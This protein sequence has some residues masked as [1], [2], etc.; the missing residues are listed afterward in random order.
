[1]SR[2]VQSEAAEEQR[3]AG[4]DAPAAPAA[5]PD[6]RGW[7]ALAWVVV[8]GSAYALIAIQARAPQLWSWIVT[9]TRNTFPSSVFD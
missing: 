6:W 7:V 1:M 9:L 5:R 3:L 8:W 4:Q 2:L